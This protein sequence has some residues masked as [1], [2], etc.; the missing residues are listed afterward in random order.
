MS[1]TIDLQTWLIRPASYQ[2]PS[3]ALIT[4]FLSNDEY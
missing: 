2:C 3:L 4:L 1:I